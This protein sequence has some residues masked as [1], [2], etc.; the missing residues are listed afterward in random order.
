MRNR[1][2]E[3]DRHIHRLAIFV[4]VRFGG[5]ASSSLFLL[6]SNVFAVDWLRG[7]GRE[8]GRGGRG[9]R[10]GGWGSARGC[11]RSSR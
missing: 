7:R 6:L 1:V 3:P 5:L 2:L 4:G 8:Q 10:R 9:E 11:H